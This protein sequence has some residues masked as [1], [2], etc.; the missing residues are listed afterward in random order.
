MGADPGSPC[1]AAIVRPDMVG[2]SWLTGLD[3]AGCTRVHLYRGGKEVWKARGFPEA[4]QVDW[5]RC[6]G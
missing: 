3:E 4:E 1:L 5:Q 2:Y 6:C